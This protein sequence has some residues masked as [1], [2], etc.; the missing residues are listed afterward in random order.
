MV[1]LYRAEVRIELKPGVADPEGA[2]TKKALELLGFKGIKT[3]KSVHAF[4]LDVDAASEADA[5]AQ[6]DE[7]CKR[8]LVNPVIH[9]P[10]VTISRA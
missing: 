4:A 1:P 8:L 9:I 2:N 6:V 10:K 3:V 5:K 7:M